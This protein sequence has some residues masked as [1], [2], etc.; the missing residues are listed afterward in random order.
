MDPSPHF[1]GEQGN[2]HLHDPQSRPH[3]EACAPALVPACRLGGD[4]QQ[5]AL[6]AGDASVEQLAVQKRGCKHSNKQGHIK[7]KDLG[8]TVGH[9]Q[10]GATLGVTVGHA[11][12]ALEPTTPLSLP[13][14]LALKLA[15]WALRHVHDTAHMGCPRAAA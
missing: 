9:F 6:R 5:Q 13:A 7:G 10:A 2:R 15:H 12:A 14:A 8:V 11:Q 3:Q 4:E 1:P